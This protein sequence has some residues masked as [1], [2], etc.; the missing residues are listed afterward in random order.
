MKRVWLVLRDCGDGSLIESVV[1][2][3]ETDQLARQ[4]VDRAGSGSGLFVE[5]H[6]ILTKLRN[7]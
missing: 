7:Y 2:V 4:H 3:Y 5:R 1:A 6:E